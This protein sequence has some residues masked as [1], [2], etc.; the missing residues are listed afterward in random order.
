M[1]IPKIIHQIYEDLAGPPTSLLK[2]AESWRELNPDWE[3]RFWNKNDIEV[4]LKEYYPELIEKYNAFPY[5]VQRWDAIRYLI[6]YKLG[7]LY[8]DMDY[9][10]TEN[11][12]ALFCNVECAMGLEPFGN[13]VR[14][15]LPYIVGNAFMATIPRHPY[16]AELIN[17]VFNKYIDVHKY[18]YVDELIV[19]TTGSYM[20]TYVYDKSKY[21]DSV[22]LIPGELVAPLN[23]HEI[24]KVM[25]GCTSKFIRNKIE[26]SFA[27]HYFFNSWTNQTKRVVNS[28]DGK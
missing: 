24:Q 6:L 15:P 27:I 9:E 1:K 5:N 11:I 12:T 13:L 16:F 26:H 20:T 19:N 18:E 17:E 22:A 21:K 7:G 23:Q 8:V 28:F 25:Q 10:C 4:F 2:I 14:T 3:Y